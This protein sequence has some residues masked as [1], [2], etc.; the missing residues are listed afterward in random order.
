MR[1]EIMNKVN[2]SLIIYQKYLELVF[3]TNDLVRKFPKCENFALSAEIIPSATLF[4]IFPGPNNPILIIAICKHTSSAL[5][6]L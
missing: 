2:T 3:Y 1:L 6:Y 5:L 4:A